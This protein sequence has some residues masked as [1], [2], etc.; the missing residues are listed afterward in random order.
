[1]K[2]HR[3]KADAVHIYNYCFWGLLAYWTCV[4]TF[5]AFRIFCFDCMDIDLFLS[6]VVGGIAAGVGLVFSEYV[7]IV[8][9]IAV[10]EY[11]HEFDK[12]F[13]SKRI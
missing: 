5:I 9:E 11:E 8:R 10:Q 4:V 6:L 13:Y 2:L 7:F 1:M 3:L 12:A